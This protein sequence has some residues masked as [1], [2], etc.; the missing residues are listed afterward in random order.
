MQVGHAGVRVANGGGEEF[1]EAASGVLAGIDDQRWNPDRGGRGDGS[2]GPDDG[3]L[4]GLLEHGFSV[5]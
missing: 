1:R 2:G 4:S 5:I 3:Q